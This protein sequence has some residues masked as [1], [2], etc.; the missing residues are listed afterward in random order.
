[1][2]D[3]VALHATAALAR[4][5]MIPGSGVLWDTVCEFG[6]DE[7]LRFD[8]DEHSRKFMHHL[9]RLFVLTRPQEMRTQRTRRSVHVCAPQPGAVVGLLEG[10]RLEI[11]EGTQR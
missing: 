7:D 3:K 1:M 11:P 4:L 2:P 6:T 5:P 10:A 9:S 8:L